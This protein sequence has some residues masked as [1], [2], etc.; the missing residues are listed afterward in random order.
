MYDDCV[1]WMLPQFIVAAVGSGLYVYNVPMKSV[2]AYRKIAHD[3][4]VLHTMLQKDGY[5]RRPIRSP[6]HLLWSIWLKQ[7]VFLGSWCRA[8]RTAVWGCGSYRTSPFPLN[9]PPQVSRTRPLSQL[10]QPSVW[11]FKCPLTP[12]LFPSQHTSFL[13][14]FWNW[15]R[16]SHV[17]IHL[18]ILCRVVH[19]VQSSCCKIISRET[20]RTTTNIWIKQLWC[21]SIAH[22]S[23]I[24]KQH[25]NNIRK[26]SI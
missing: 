16:C 15:S 13:P 20:S 4:N 26:D 5:E 3:S 14:S 18:A 24:L 11:S 1:M 17:I 12:F 2:V 9:P 25:Y 7:S 21:S 22:N 6:K 23:V 19:V 8:L 10:K